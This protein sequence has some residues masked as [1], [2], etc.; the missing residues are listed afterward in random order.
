MSALHAGCSLVLADDSVAYRRALVS[1]LLRDPT[2]SILGD[3]GDGEAAVGAVGRTRPD[4][5]LLDVMMPRLD[6][7]EAARR[8][9]RG[10]G[11]PVLLMSPLARIPEQRPDLSSLPPHLVE[12][13]D[14][15]VLV[16]AAGPANIAALIGRMKALARIGHAGPPREP[17]RRPPP[18]SCGVVVI[19]ASTG[20]MEALRTVLGRLPGSFPPVVI[21]QHLDPVLGAQFAGLLQ[22]AIGQTVVPVEVSAPL[23][24]S[25]I[26]V[27]APFHHVIVRS[28]QVA[29][30]PAQEGE[31][32]P[33]ADRLFSS[34]A[35][36]YA[37]RAVGIVLT[38]M[39]RDGASGLREL[40]E[41]S[42]W[43]I[44]QDEASSL[45][46]GMPRAAMDKGACCEVLPL[47]RIAERLSRLALDNGGLP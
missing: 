43:T 47:S 32:A 37:K 1:A 21:A 20:G 7:L 12:L 33:S 31:L 39:G 9:T 28:G 17:E 24:P 15:P 35:A 41:A 18:A 14:K 42:G 45:V 44:A 11:V 34:A 8:I 13:V 19:A 2:I 6:G 22:N 26:Y 10:Y 29:A 38:G 23:A 27:A 5:A 3:V 25:R 46:G 36:S 16:G 30:R 4:V 40:R